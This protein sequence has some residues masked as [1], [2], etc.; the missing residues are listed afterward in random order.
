MMSC[1]YSLLGFFIP[2]AAFDSDTISV[3]RGPEV[4][5]EVAPETSFS[6]LQIIFYLVCFV[7]VLYFASR[8]ARWLGGKAGGRSGFHLRLVETLY[9]GPNRALHLVMV[10]KQ[11][12]LVG[13]A[14]RNL[15][16]LAEI[17]DPDLLR[18]LQAELARPVAERQATGK[19]FSDYLKGLL[20]G[21]P[22]EP[23]TA[24]QPGVMTQAQRIE[25]RLMKYR[26]HRGHKSDG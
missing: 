23:E 16:F 14:E 25:E 5:P 24:N 26:S 22:S 2:L 8:V 3:S 9:I 13:A 17:H 11:L 1:L 12:F 7:L 10:G 19:G 21:G 4:S 15:T 6:Y 18:A 20:N